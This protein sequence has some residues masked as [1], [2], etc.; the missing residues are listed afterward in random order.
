MAGAPEHSSLDDDRSPGD[1]RELV[2]SDDVRRNADR[3]SEAVRSTQSRPSPPSSPSPPESEQ[4]T[5]A[6]GGG[7]PST[8]LDPRDQPPGSDARALELAVLESLGPRWRIGASAAERLVP[9]VATALEAGWTSEDLA[10]HL[11]ASPEGVRSP[12]AVL[13]ARLNDLPSPPAARRQRPHW[14][15]TCDE[16][17]RMRETID[18][19]PFRC[20]TCH[21]AVVGDESGGRVERPGPG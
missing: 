13:S 6:P 5:D 4:W 15:G 16:L 19:Q 9:S 17:T 1:S 11:G 18:E 12:Y 14:C 10:K 2:S 7:G 8:A 3:T 21:P 20:P